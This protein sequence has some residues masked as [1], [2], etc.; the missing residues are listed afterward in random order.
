MGDDNSL[1]QLLNSEPCFRTAGMVLRHSGLYF[2]LAVFAMNFLVWIFVS[3]KAFVL[4]IINSLSLSVAVYA[5]NEAGW[6]VNLRFDIGPGK[7]VPLCL[8]GQIRVI[9]LWHLLFV[10]ILPSLAGFIISHF[11]KKKTNAP[12]Q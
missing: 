11:I 4:S 2:L 6:I 10:V 9:T 5:A 7:F 12:N 3:K 8:Q 1:V